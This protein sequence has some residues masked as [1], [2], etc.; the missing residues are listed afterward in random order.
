ME[1]RGLAVPTYLLLQSYHTRPLLLKK[2]FILF[3]FGGVKGVAEVQL[4]SQGFGSSWEAIG[5]Q[6][7]DDRLVPGDISVSRC[8]TVDVQRVRRKTPAY[9]SSAWRAV[10]N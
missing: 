10:S 8:F 2:A 4:L 9:S 7:R 1:A 6:I 5:G 3:R